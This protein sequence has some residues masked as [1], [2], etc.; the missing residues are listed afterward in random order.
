MGSVDADSLMRKVYESTYGI[1]N[2]VKNDGLKGKLRRPLAEV[3]FHKGEDFTGGSALED[4]MRVFRDLPI[5]EIYRISYLEFMSLPVHITDM[6]MRVAKEKRDKESVI[7]NKATAELNNA[8]KA[9]R[10]VVNRQ[11]TFVPKPRPF[12]KK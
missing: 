12:P 2:H 7:A 8:T 6:M 1:F 9:H 3:A 11:P 10:Q 4:T 5:G